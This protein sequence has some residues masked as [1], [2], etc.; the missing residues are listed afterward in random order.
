MGRID[1]EWIP[2]DYLSHSEGSQ[3]QRLKAIDMDHVPSHSDFNPAHV[4]KDGRG[5]SVAATSGA[6]FVISFSCCSS[7]TLVGKAKN[8][9]LIS[10]DSGCGDE[11][12]FF[13]TKPKLNLIEV[14]S[15][16]VL[17]EK[18]GESIK[19]T[20]FTDSGA[21]PQGRFWPHNI[22]IDHKILKN[23]RD[24]ERVE[25]SR[26]CAMDFKCISLISFF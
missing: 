17:E 20:W 6:L 18:F 16:Q 9:F 13:D 19:N 11:N 15:S 10:M 5:G 21:T 3:S 12:P 23:D 22:T 24:I 26:M 1:C 8:I 25:T 7:Y 4:I 14:G 2:F